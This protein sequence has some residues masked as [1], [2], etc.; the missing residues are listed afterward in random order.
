MCYYMPS[1]SLDLEEKGE[2]KEKVSCCSYETFIPMGFYGQLTC[3]HT[4]IFI[5]LQIYILFQLSL[6]KGL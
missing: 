6:G 4:H 1:T 3:T 2:S 5:Y